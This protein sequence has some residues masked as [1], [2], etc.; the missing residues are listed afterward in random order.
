VFGGASAT[1]HG[2]RGQKPAAKQPGTMS[3]VLEHA[4]LFL[5]TQADA[6]FQGLSEY[7]KITM[8]H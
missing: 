8:I 5:C 1:A 7:T 4:T 6:E 2:G 3:V